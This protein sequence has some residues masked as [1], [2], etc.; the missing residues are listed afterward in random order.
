MICDRCFY[1]TNN[2]EVFKQHQELC[3]HYLH[4]E[5]A[6]SILPSDFG[7]IIKFNNLSRTIR[8]PLVY[9]A[10][11]TFMIFIS[12]GHQQQLSNAFHLFEVFCFSQI[13]YI[14]KV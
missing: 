9:Y 10:D 11:L 13:T 4:H 8:A 1:H 2:E 14:S 5:T 6:I 12:Q 7:N 3:D